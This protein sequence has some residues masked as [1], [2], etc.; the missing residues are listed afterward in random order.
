LVI[1]ASVTPTP[2]LAAATPG[3]THVLA[4]ARFVPHG[5]VRELAVVPIQS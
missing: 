1:K 2:K 5:V 3:F 4:G